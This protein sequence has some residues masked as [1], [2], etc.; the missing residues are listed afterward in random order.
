MQLH[1]PSYPTKNQTKNIDPTMSVSFTRKILGYRT[2]KTEKAV[3]EDITFEE[4]KRL[5]RA[6]STVQHSGLTT[7]CELIN[8]NSDLVPLG[9]I[10]QNRKS[11]RTALQLKARCRSKSGQKKL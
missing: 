4:G 8:S 10:S 11:S 5:L 2:S 7:P 3:E 9:E 6:C 1:S